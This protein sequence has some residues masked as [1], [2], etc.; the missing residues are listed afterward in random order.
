MKDFLELCAERFSARLFT[1]A[2]V[3]EADLQYVLEAVRLAP[4]AVN[5]QPWRW[6][7]VGIQGK[8]IP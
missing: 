4:S 7:V 5:R 3:S 1:D 8:S 2:P 6:L